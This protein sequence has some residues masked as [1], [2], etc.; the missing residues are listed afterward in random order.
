MNERRL[1]GKGGGGEERRSN[2]RMILRYS[3]RLLWGKLSIYKDNIHLLLHIQRPKPVIN[4][5]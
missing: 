3:W 2:V 4:S 5:T 1:R